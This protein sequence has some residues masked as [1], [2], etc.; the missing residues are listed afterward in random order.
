MMKCPD[1][2]GDLTQIFYEEVPI[3]F[4]SD[5]NGRL[6]DEQKLEKIEIARRVKV[7]RDKKH[8]KPAY[9]EV[10]RVC[11][12]CEVPMQKAKYGK[13]TP[14]TI[15]KCP[16]CNSIWLDEGELEDIQVAYEMYEDNVN[17]GKKKN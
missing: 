1:C 10:G 15:D 6:V 11:P 5:C 13:Y 9:Y 12:A 3:H 16:E 7:P 8:S 17:K 4:C 2:K 14:R